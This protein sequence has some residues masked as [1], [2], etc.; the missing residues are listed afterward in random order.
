MIGGG[1]VEVEKLN[2]NYAMERMTRKTKKPS[3]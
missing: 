1:Y 3:R 2:A